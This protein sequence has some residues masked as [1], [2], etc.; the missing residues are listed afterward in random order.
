MPGKNFVYMRKGWKKSLRGDKRHAFCIASM[1]LDMSQE[2]G[3]CVIPHETQQPLSLLKFRSILLRTQKETPDV[4]FL[5]HVATFM[6]RADRTKW[7]WY[8]FYM[9]HKM[10]ENW[11]FVLWLRVCLMW[12]FLVDSREKKTNKNSWFCL[13]SPFS[14]ERISLEKIPSVLEANVCNRC[15]PDNL[16]RIGRCLLS[17]YCFNNA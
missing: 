13:I 4:G 15:S 17:S 8:S 11:P 16:L 2:W 12:L 10:D 1:R 3:L 14:E 6:V 9:N 5:H 7:E